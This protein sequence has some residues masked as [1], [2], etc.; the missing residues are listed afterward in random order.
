M[1]RTSVWEYAAALRPAYLAGGKGER[2]RLLSEFCRA[3]GYH[4]KAAIRL[5]RPPSAVVGGGRGRPAVYGPAVVAAL[6]RLWE[7]SDQACGKRL[8]P[9]LP[10]L[11]ASLERH[12]ELVVSSEVHEQ[13]LQLSAATIDRL[14]RPARQRGLRRP[15]THRAAS[16]T[17]KAQIPV[18]TFGEWE[19][20]AAGSVQADLVAHC[21]ESTEG[22]HLW[23]LTVVDVATSWTECLVVWGKGQHRVSAAL[24]EMRGRLPMVLRELHTDNGSEFLNHLLAPYCQREG[25]RQTRG[26]PYRKNDQ[27]YV[28]QKN[29]AVVRR[30]VGYDRYSS[31]EAEKQLARLYE[32]VRLYGNFF[33]PVRKLVSKERVGARVV[34]RYDR[35]QTPYQRLLTVGALDEGERRALAAQYERLNPLRLRQQIDAALEALWKLADRSDGLPVNHTR[36]VAACG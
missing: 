34:K 26:R 11:V 33:Q 9:F 3:T 27:A 20:V 10:E 13:L 12:G 16:T 7:T 22:F 36:A 8:A 24:H 5:L 4:R 29:G 1:T 17:L 19:G 21:G 23:T 14:L 25:I 28:E 31:H 30:F 35:A 2:G 15:W 32:R 18:R 6:V